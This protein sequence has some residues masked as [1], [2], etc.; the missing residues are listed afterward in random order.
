VN[1]NEL[2]EELR[3]SGIQQESVLKAIQ[4]VPREF[5]IEKDLE[6]LAYENRALPIE[7]QQ[8]ISQPYIVALMTQALNLKG[9]EKILEIGTGSG[10]QTAILARLCQRI[11]TIERIPQLLSTAKN[12]LESL[13][14]SNIIYVSGDG[15]LGYEKEAPYDGIIVT[16]ATPSVPDSYLSQLTENGRLVIPVGT[17]KKQ[18]LELWIKKDKEFRVTELCPCRFVPLIGQQGWNDPNQDG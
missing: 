7:S 8:T 1:V 15:T 11:I 13:H 9:T 16:A 4:D 18:S 2:I 17:R 6:E 12:N 5:F 14:F 10:Y 3:N